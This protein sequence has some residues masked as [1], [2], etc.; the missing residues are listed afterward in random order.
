MIRKYVFGKPFETEAVIEKVMPSKGELP[1]FTHIKEGEFTLDLLE[2][3][4]VYGLGEQIRGIN[5]RGWQYVNWNFDNP[6]HHEDTHSLYGSHNFL[7]VSGDC[8][9]NDD[10]RLF[11][12]F[13]D[14]P[15]KIVFD[16]GYERRDKMTVTAASGDIAV[17][18][19]EASSI[20]EIVRQFRG[21]IGQSYIAPLWAFGY[22]QSR[23]GYKNEADIREVA[24]KYEELE[25]PLDSI[26][27]DI[28]YMERYK[29][30][31]VDSDRFA[32][33]KALAADMKAK[34]I[35]L[36][37]II[38]AGVK[39]EEGYDVY[40][41]G[42]AKNYFCKDKDGKDFIGAVW[43]GKVH[44]P[45]FMQPE[46]REWFG[47]KYE[48]LTSLGIDGFWN[49]MNEPANFYTED[50]LDEVLEQ[51][52]EL[53][54]RNIGITDYFDFVNRVG[55]MNGNE[56]AYDKFY[57]NINGEMV[58]HSAIH[59]LYGMNMTRA[60]NEALCKIDPEKRTLF[61]SRSSYIGAH[62]YGGI[63]QGDNKSWWT[64]I[65]QGLQQLPA[66]NMAGFIYIG[67]DVGGFG[68]DTTEDLMMR[69][70]QFAMFTPLMRN[71]SADGTRRQELYQF[72]NCKALG[73][74]IK[75]RYAL[76]PYLYSEYLKAV[77]NDDMMFRP[78]AFDF[79]EDM[80]AATVEDQLLVGDE[81]MIAPIYKQ[82]ARGRYVYIPED[83][84]TMI[85]MRSCSDYEETK[86]SKG[87]HYV[88]ANLNEVVFFV[89]SGQ[90]I[91]FTKPAK[92]TAELTS[93]FTFIGDKASKY[94]LYSDDGI[95]LASSKTL[96]TTI[97]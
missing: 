60:A 3:D 97:I 52:A 16:I 7:I 18:I 8:G 96:T 86:I 77:I 65:L 49:D 26:Y 42:V 54:G 24:K 70:H 50:I 93:E 31:T 57:H 47:R 5:K 17:Y 40:E 33:L 58:Q 34:N 22:G 92:T 55:G 83:G 81:L 19:I 84:M 29:D 13:F 76:I 89:R 35:H 6:H 73:E 87:H 72:S 15:G 38:D 80:D 90:K 2:N 46:A 20:R 30:F 59:N 41:E 56:S 74:M 51:A 28:D 27:M 12:V 23:W 75:I 48:A 37:P 95:S 79:T 10:E 62:R 94:E 11:G 25:I 43:P 4:I 32:D 88:E 53:K 14:Y 66:L 68:S 67:A 63:W 91:P 21:I 45:D 9:G 44:F 85:R 82:N 78:L 61:F 39:I 1:Y 71:H 36:V 64:H 69:W